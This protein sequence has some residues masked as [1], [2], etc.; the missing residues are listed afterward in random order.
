MRAAYRR[1]RVTS[2]RRPSDRRA[3][4]ARK[5]R[6]IVERRRHPRRGRCF[7]HGQ[8]CR[9]DGNRD[10]GQW[11]PVR[12]QTRLTEGDRDPGEVKGAK[13]VEEPKGFIRLSGPR[14]GDRNSYI[15][16]SESYPASLADAGDRRLAALRGSST[17]KGGPYGT[18]PEDPQG[19]H[20][21]GLPPAPPPRRR[22]PRRHPGGNRPPPRG[23]PTPTATPPGGSS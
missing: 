10:G 17:P 5:C 20:D 18:T 15:S 3:G 23:R 8:R 11:S 2:T 22:R 4:W 6:S 19:P 7:G 12:N 16:S 13:W 9:C 21:A 1:A 14:A